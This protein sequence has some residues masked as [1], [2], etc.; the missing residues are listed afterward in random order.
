V[1]ERDSVQAG[2]GVKVAAICDRGWV[3]SIIGETRD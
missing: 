1:G 3:V 2:S